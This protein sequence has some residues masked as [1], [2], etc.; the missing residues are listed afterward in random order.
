VSFNSKAEAEKLVSHILRFGMHTDVVA[1][2]LQEAYLAGRRD[3]PVDEARE[4]A[5]RSFER[6]SPATRE[7]DARQKPT[8]RQLALLE[9]VWQRISEKG[10]PP[11]LREIA[12]GLGVGSTNAVLDHIKALE[13]KG[14]VK[15]DQPKSRS[16]RLIDWPARRTILDEMRELGDPEHPLERVLLVCAQAADHLEHAMDWDGHG[17]ETVRVAVRAAAAYLEGRMPT[18]EELGTGPGSPALEAIRSGVFGRRKD[19]GDQ[20]HH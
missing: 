10:S 8:P 11:T 20:D 12:I 9:F 14:Y 15:R 1:T 17:W 2:W 16:L 3:G 5:R 18:A 4:V 19:H 6:S 13:R 7:G